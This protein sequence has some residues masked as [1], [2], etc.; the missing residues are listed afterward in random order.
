MTEDEMGLMVSWIH[1][2]EFGQTP[3]DDEEQGSQSQTRLSS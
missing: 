2:H 1:G 3:G